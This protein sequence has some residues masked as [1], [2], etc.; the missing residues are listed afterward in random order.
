MITGSCLCGKIA[1]EVSGTGD[2]MYYCHCRMCRK[3]SGSSF[4]TN[5]LMKESDFAITTG[6]SHLRGYESSPGETR[7]F[8]GECGSPLF[9]RADARPG[10]ISLRCGTLDAAPDLAPE[11][12]L[13]TAWKAPWYEIADSLRQVSDLKLPIH[14]VS[15]PDPD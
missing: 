7:Y 6:A 11:V 14:A 8:C 5:M 4:A 2:S 9:G 12:H 3:A 10:L 1:Y 15:E 13:F